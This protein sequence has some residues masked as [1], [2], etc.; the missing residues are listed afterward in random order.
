MSQAEKERFARENHS[1]IERRRRN[2]M[3]TYI[4]ELSDMVPSCS[5]LARKPDKLTI[6]RMAVSHMKQLR[7]VM[8][9]GLDKPAFLTD[10]ELKH[11]VLESM[12]GFLFVV[13]CESARILFVSDTVTTVINQAHSDWIGHVFYDLI[14][15]QDVTRVQEQLS[16]DDTRRSSYDAKLG[17][18]KKE[19]SA[20]PPA[21]PVCDGSRKGF[22]CRMRCGKAQVSSAP[23]RYQ[24]GHIE[25]VADN[26]YAVMRVTG[27]IRLWPSGGFNENQSGLMDENTI[28]GEYCLL[29]IARLHT[30]TQP[31]YGELSPLSEHIEFVTRQDLDNVFTY[32]D[33]RIVMILGF[34][35]RDLLG[36]R[37][38]DICLPEDADK[39]ID[40]YKQVL[41]MKG[42]AFSAVCRIQNS[43]SEHVWFRVTSHAFQNPYTSE[44]ECI[45]SNF[46]LKQSLDDSHVIEH[47][48]QTP[49]RR[50]QSYSIG[51]SADRSPDVRSPTA[52]LSYPPQTIPYTLSH[53][54]QF[55]PVT[56][57]TPSWVSHSENVSD[58]AQALADRYPVALSTQH[59]HAAAVLAQPTEVFPVEAYHG[60]ENMM[61]MMIPSTATQGEFTELF[62]PFSSA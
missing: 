11:L 56:G 61:A 43:N 39:L 16:V 22:I 7:G 30:T 50:E 21:A 35:P 51:S 10:Q 40:S 57:I 58:Y 47:K 9:G 48:N 27:Y 37:P 46:S 44:V 59:G 2:K 14:H 34:Q 29:A 26:M 41:V 18:I 23:P 24:R 31:S 1:E 19:A 62:T 28:G 17:L 12:D 49:Y 42:Q 36:K 53:V 6:L 55:N 4:T 38:T 13:S 32:V 20:S 25:A 52:T 33:K 60:Q 15:P 8:V 3:T 45:V 5:A 54:G